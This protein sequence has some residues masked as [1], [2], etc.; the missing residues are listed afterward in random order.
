[1]L[2]LDLLTQVCRLWRVHLAQMRPDITPAGSPERSLERAAV[3]DT[4]GRL[5][6]VERLSPET[7]PRKMQIAATLAHLAEGGLGMV[8]PYLA[9]VSGRQ[10][11]PLHGD[12]WQISPYLEGVP[13]PRPAWVYDAW[14]GRALADF[15]I[16]LRAAAEPLP[17]ATGAP[18]AVR[19]F[20][21]DLLDRLARHRPELTARIG[22]F[23]ACLPPDD[24]MPQAFC[25]GDYHP[26]NVIW[27]DHAIRAVIDW[28]FCGI[29]PAGYDVALLVGCVGIEE[30][31]ALAGPLVCALLGRLREAGHLAAMDPNLW[32]LVLGVRLGWLSDWLRRGDEEMVALELDYLD[33]LA[34]RR[35]AL[36]TAWTAM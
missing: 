18:H 6:L 11:L 10:V 19:A 35:G 21:L 20:A 30:P 25:H 2:S 32:A 8:Q 9:D 16:A 22:P 5:F 4:Q 36:E 26:L 1:M 7:A 27:G 17:P 12:F 23:V 24:A 33:L 34:D 3:Q 13:L 29:K 31:E 15:L 14:R 28:E